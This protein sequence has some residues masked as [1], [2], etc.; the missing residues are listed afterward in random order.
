M[1]LKVVNI[2]QELIEIVSF[3]CCITNIGNLQ[4]AQF[5]QRETSRQK[6]KTW[7][8][9]E[10]VLKFLVTD[11]LNN[12]QDDCSGIGSNDAIIVAVDGKYAV[13]D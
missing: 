10:I 6:F 3:Q 1:L 9:I 8:C 12:R 11:N 13:V 5:F 7:M 4:F 2:L